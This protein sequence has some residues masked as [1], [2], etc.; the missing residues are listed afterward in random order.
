MMN[1]V[2]SQLTSIHEHLLKVDHFYLDLYYC[3][4]EDILTNATTILMPSHG[5]ISY[6]REGT[7]RA[8]N[9]LKSILNEELND[10]ETRGYI[11]DMT[12]M[13]KPLF[14]EFRRKVLSGAESEIKISSDAIRE[15]LNQLNE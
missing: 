1:P 4:R 13:L 9:N 3:I 8:L 14:D 15:T 2:Q 5:Q 12:D 10:D 7:R 6:I 11:L